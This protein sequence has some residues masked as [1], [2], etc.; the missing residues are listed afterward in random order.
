MEI[1]TCR[2]LLPQLFKTQKYGGKIETC[3]LEVLQS[4]FSQYKVPEYG[5]P[6][7]GRYLE[8]QTGN[9]NK[10]KS[11]IKKNNYY[12]IKIFEKYSNLKKNVPKPAKTT[13]IDQTKLIY[14]MK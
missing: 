14:F 4:T 9:L 3:R 1:E 11:F 8:Y 2:F 7:Q 6:C 10:K 13:I 5:N 12:S